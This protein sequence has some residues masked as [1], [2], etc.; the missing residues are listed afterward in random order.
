[1]AKEVD[2]D[3]IGKIAEALVATS[4]L[5]DGAALAGNGL[6]MP[7][8]AL[9]TRSAR[10][11][12]VRVRTREGGKS[13][14]A[15][16]Q[17]ALVSA[18]STREREVTEAYARR[19]GP[20]AE[21][22]EREA[23][24]TGRITRDGEPLFDAELVAL[25][26]Q[27]ETVRRT[28]TGRDGRYALSVPADIDLSLEVRVDGKAQY[29]DKEPLAYPIG[30]RG[31]RDIE[32]GQ[33]APV[34]DP[35]SDGEGES[36]QMPGLE[37][38]ELERGEKTIEALGLILGKVTEQPSDRPG[39]ILAQD[40]TAGAK[41]VRGSEVTLWV[42]RKDGRSAATVG[43]LKGKTLNDAL[44]SMAKA[45]VGVASVTIV[46]GTT[47]TPTVRGSKVAERE[48]ALHLEVAVGGEKAAETEVAAAV[49][50][51][52]S[53]APDIDSAAAGERWLAEAGIDSLETLGK[54]A[55]EDDPSLRKRLGLSPR[56]DVSGA[57]RALLAA[58]MRVTRS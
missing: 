35:S 31:V 14:A 53:E 56:A 43:D 1:M 51:A 52:A 11:E 4:R 10:R 7:M 19:A 39:I 36:L 21:I 12:L 18:L 48:D 37:G 34:C 50:A 5:Q 58:A 6:L 17:A 16:R 32:I 15:V 25:D 54:A 49:L 29:R 30:Y 20:Q 40:P 27:R 8:A 46:R 47:Q 33:A 57:R 9:R 38:L 42:G 26:G 22:G 44:K 13:D 55:G 2:D 28:C 3:T 45:K 41:V 24:L 23:G